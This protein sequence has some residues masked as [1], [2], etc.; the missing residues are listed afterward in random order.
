MKRLFIII[1]L[2]LLFI[3]I[4]SEARLP[5]IVRVIYFQPQ[6]APP[7]PQAEYNRL[8]QDIQ[9]FFRSE[10]E[11]H[12]YAPKTFTYETDVNNNLIVHTI[13]GK[14]NTKHYEGEVFTTYYQKIAKEI[15]F[16]INNTTNRDAQNDV[17]IVFIG[18][19]DL[20]LN[21]TGTWGG[22]WHF[23]GNTTGGTAIINDTF[24]QTYPNHFLSIIAHEFAHALSLG[25]NQAFGSLLG[26][27]GL[28]FG[29]AGYLTHFEARLL[30]VHPIFNDGHI[31]NAPPSIAGELTLE[32]IGDDAVR[33]TLP[34]SSDVGL[35]HCQ[36][37]NN[38]SY[39]AFA[40]LTGNEDII[41]INADRAEIKDG[42]ILS[43][44]ILDIHGNK[45]DYIV[46]NI[47]LPA[48]VAIERR[49][50]IKN[51]DLPFTPEDE[52]DKH[53][54]IDKPNNS[55]NERVLFTSWARLKQR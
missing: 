51:P 1:L 47:Q 48:P 24:K 25:H 3:P 6:G 18:G 11:R 14:H 12:R 38:Q 20:D 31:K 16:A 9:S 32:A 35:Y 45:R 22:G 19:T 2:G 50:R 23:I 53:V 42:D 44:I 54:H 7:A 40:K 17:Y 8:L 27:P 5:F 52:E 21:F 30:N 26:P 28:P 15:P 39:L 49:P 36:L 55:T 43:F 33:L 41:T 46:P 4:L 13:R 29:D 10:M 34:V 37:R